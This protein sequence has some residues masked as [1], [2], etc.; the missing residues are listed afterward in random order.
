MREQF[1]DWSPR[2]ESLSL[3][4]QSIAICE[5]Y[6]GQGYDLT[7][8]QLYYQ[9]VARAVIENT[10][11][12]YKKLGT[13]IDN[14]R[15]AGLLDWSFIVDRTRNAYRTDGIDT[16]PEDAIITA[17]EGYERALWDTQ[18]NHVEVWIEKEALSGIAQRAAQGVRTIYF[19]CRGY[20]SQ[21][22][23]YAAGKRFAAYGRDGKNNYVIHLGDHDPS[24]IDMTRDIQDRL[25]MF[26]GP[27]APEVRRIALNMDQVEQYNPPPNFAKMTDS[28]FADYQARFGDES[29]ELDALDPNTLVSLITDEVR[30][31]IDPDAWAEAEEREETEKNQLRTVAQSWD[32]VIDHLEA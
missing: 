1:I 3:V 32:D 8:R 28:R 15:L 20:G 31:L 23:M 5:D 10:F 16:S 24:G 13:L 22:E 17:A 29:W 4:N 6:R 14:A 25:Q 7:L 27:Y 21:S 12:S 30:G 19:S 9:L 26:A 2:G 18:P 11:Q